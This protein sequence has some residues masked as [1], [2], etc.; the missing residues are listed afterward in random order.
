MPYDSPGEE[1]RSR[2]L[3]PLEP[4]PGTGGVSWR[5]RCPNGHEVEVVPYRLRAETTPAVPHAA[6]PKQGAA[7]ARPPRS[8]TLPS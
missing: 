1:I 7:A 4:Y 6:G 3:V 2:G 5:C 8:S